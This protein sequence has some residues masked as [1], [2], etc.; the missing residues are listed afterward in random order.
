MNDKSKIN[1]AERSYQFALR[2]IKMVSTLPNSIVARELSRQ[3]IRSATSIGANVEEALGALT[4]NGFTNSMN[5]AK[6][7]ARETK[8]W[9]RL[10]VGVELIKEEKVKS[11]LQENVELINIFSKIVKTCQLGG[12][13][14]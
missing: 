6:K 8:Y 10:I 9:I 11:L 5:I 4:K 13:K 3:L 7:E 1:L 14:R 12:K 2:V